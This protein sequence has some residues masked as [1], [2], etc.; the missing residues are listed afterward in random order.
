[1]AKSQ[2]GVAEE[3]LRKLEDQLTCAICLD[4]FKDPKL[5]QCFHVYCKDC[6]QRLVFRQDNDQDQPSLHCP[7]CRQATLLPPNGVSGLQSAFHIHHLFEIQ[8]ALEKIKAP[9]NVK[10]EKCTKTVQTATN[11]CRDC[12]KFICDK[13]TDL[14]SE[15]EDFSSHELVGVD[16]VTS[17]V[18]ELM[19]LRKVRLYCEQHHDQGKE[20]DLFCETCGELIC[21]HCTVKKHKDHQYDLVGDTFQRHEAEITASLEPVEKQLGAVKKA[22]RELDVQL[23]ELDDLQATLTAD[24]QRQVRMLQELL[25]ARKTDLVSQAEQIIQAKKMN[26]VAQ[27]NDLDT[28]QVKLEGCLSFVKES[29]RTGSQGEVMK[30][31]KVVVK[32]IKEVTDDF[33]PDTLSP[34]ETANVKF[35]SCYQLAESVC[36]QFGEVRLRA[37]PDKSHATGKGLVV[38]NSDERATAV[39]HVVDDTGKACPT[40]VDALT[41]QLASN[42]HNT[43]IHCSVK[44][45]EAIGQ[46]E[47]S[48]QPTSRGRHQLHIKVEGEHIKG[49]PFPVTVKLPVWRLGTPVKTITGVKKPFGIA[50]SQVGNIVVAEAGGHCVSIFS[51]AGEKIKSFG[52]RGSIREGQFDAPKGV[53]LD[54]EDNILVADCYNDR[55]QKFTSNGDVIATANGSKFKHPIGIAVHPHSQQV[56]VADS[57]YHRVQILNPDLTFYGSFGSYGSSNGQFQYA[58][59]IAFDSLGNVYVVDGGNSRIQVF[60]AHGRFLRRFGRK[61]KGRGEFDWPNTI[62]IDGDDVVYVVDQNNNR[63]SVF[64]CAGKFLTTFGTKGSGEGQFNFP[65]GVTVNNKN[66]L[67]YVGDH[68]N[69][70]Q[71]F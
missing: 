62:S 40:A 25:E 65:Y 66:G 36:Q 39:V 11:F 47:I 43:M 31:K 8:E 17:S 21:L 48:Y 46:Y 41:C 4:A 50:V 64:T 63:V 3:A 61:G 58:Y 14:H 23:L 18:K 9:Q 2:S 7:T 53:A 67:V 35:T 52:C 6:L 42:D 28:L 27:A 29:L 10:C 56:Y 59:D 44:M 22:R 37:S 24:I 54:F 32:Q 45:T 16:H 51:P 30:M 49:S 70:I 57:N 1:M 19:P 26:L 71:I 55:I 38:A 68:A 20:L 15:W 60:T 12:G 5:L 34:C 33:K 69:R 13:C